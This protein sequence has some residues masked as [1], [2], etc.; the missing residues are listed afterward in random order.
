MK[1]DEAKPREPEVQEPK[2]LTEDRREFLGRSVGTAPLVLTLWGG[3]GW[4]GKSGF[5]SLWGSGQKKWPKKRYWS[6]VGAR[7]NERMAHFR[8][9]RPD[10]P[11]EKDG[12]KS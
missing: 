12:R 8:S 3:S 10:E 11:D 2:A 4:G 5:G 7:G 6:K 9:W 1:R